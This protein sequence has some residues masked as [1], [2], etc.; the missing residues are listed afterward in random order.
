MNYELVRS[1]ENSKEYKNSRSL[2]AVLL[3]IL[4]LIVITPKVELEHRRKSPHG[5]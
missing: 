3:P 5:S 4:Y 1:K 2:I